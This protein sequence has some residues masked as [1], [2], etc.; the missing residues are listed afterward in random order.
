MYFDRNQGGNQL[1]LQVWETVDS[2]YNGH[3]YRLSVEISILFIS[4]LWNND[5]THLKK[6]PVNNLFTSRSLRDEWFWYQHPPRRKQQSS[7]SWWSR[8]FPDG[9]HR[10]TGGV[11]GG[12]YILREFYIASHCYS[13]SRQ[14]HLTWLSARATVSRQ[15]YCA[16]WSLRCER[17]DTF[18][19]KEDWSCS[20]WPEVLCILQSDRS[21]RKPKAMYPR[22]IGWFY[23]LFAYSRKSSDIYGLIL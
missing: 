9:A 20:P 19:W 11:E 4:L 23:F 13:V 16:N 15:D 1:P 5:H 12:G 2:Y 17:G 8:K 3:T 10:E 14:C 18:C 22:I 6:N 7:T 21:R